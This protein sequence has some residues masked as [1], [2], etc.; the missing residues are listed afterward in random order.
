MARVKVFS[1]S[2]SIL[3]QWIWI[4]TS[5]LSEFKGNIDTDCGRADDSV[6]VYVYTEMNAVQSRHNIYSAWVSEVYCLLEAMGFPR[7]YEGD[8]MRERER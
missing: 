6:N 1:D 4:W 7:L 8:S 3:R 2:R 5:D